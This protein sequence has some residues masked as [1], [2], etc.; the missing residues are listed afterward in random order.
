M[1]EEGY[2]YLPGLLDTESINPVYRDVMRLCQEQGWSDAQQKPLLEEAVCEGQDQFWD[3]YD[4]LQKL[5]SFH[6][7]AHHPNLLKVIQK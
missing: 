2:L 4:G 6:G 3:V 1:K 7:L 5:E